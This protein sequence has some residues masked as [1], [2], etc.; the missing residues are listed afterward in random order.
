MSVGFEPEQVGNRA[1]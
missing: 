1:I